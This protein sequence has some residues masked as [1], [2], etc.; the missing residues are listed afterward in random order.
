MLGAVEEEHPL[1]LASG[2]LSQGGRQGAEGDHKPGEK[3]RPKGVSRPIIGHTPVETRTHIPCMWHPGKGW[4]LTRV[5]PQV[6]D[7]PLSSGG[8]AL[9]CESLTWGQGGR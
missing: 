5:H 7:N 4:F 3:R 1:H 9:M 2:S 6:A 8:P